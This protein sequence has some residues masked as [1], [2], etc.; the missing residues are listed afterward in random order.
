MVKKSPRKLRQAPSQPE[1]TQTTTL[2]AQVYVSYMCT[3]HTTQEPGSRLG[4]F[5][6]LYLKYAEYNMWK[7]AKGHQNTHPHLHSQ[8]L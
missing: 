1:G 6:N 4:L 3:I 5:Y 7:L 8:G 2:T